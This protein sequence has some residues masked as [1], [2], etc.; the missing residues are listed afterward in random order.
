MEEITE[1]TV[2]NL[3]GV[4]VGV[5]NIWERTYTLPDGT[6]RSGL[7]A[8]LFILVNDQNP[9]I[10]VGQGSVVTVGA[11][12]WEVIAVT[13]AGQERGTVTLKELAAPAS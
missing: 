3:N 4:R 10:V 12:R 5:G 7:T 6:V 8:Q 2:G 1:T 11:S 9:G 13:K